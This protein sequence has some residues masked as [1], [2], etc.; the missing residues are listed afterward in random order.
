MTKVKVKLD[1][2]HQNTSFLK[3]TTSMTQDHFFGCYQKEQLEWL[4]SIIWVKM[5]SVNKYSDRFAEFN[6]LI[7][8]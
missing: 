4:C 5:A 1:T 7:E 3:I 6:G 8:G 2:T